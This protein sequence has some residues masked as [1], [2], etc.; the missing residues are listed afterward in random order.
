MCK[1][2]FVYVCQHICPCLWYAV[3]VLLFCG[4]IGFSSSY[5]SGTNIQFTF[6]FVYTISSPKMLAHPVFFC[7][8]L[9][10]LNIVHLPNVGYRQVTSFCDFCLLSQILLIIVHRS[11]FTCCCCR[12]KRSPLLY[13]WL[14]VARSL[15]MY[16]SI[17]RQEQI[18]E[19]SIS[20][21]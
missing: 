8:H 4:K 12:W 11:T 2:M 7:L 6:D 15:K 14:S 5:C 16:W 10:R 21:V 1:L 20:K 17:D 13:R 19:E 3:C 18:T 9:L